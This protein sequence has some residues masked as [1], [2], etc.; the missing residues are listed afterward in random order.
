MFAFYSSESFSEI[1]TISFAKK[2][3]GVK[4]RSCEPLPDCGAQCFLV[5]CMKRLICNSSTISC[6]SCLYFSFSSTVGSDSQHF[7][8]NHN[9]YCQ[10]HC[11]HSRLLSE[12]F[13]KSFSSLRS[14]LQLKI[15]SFF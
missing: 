7:S 12:L 6:K 10:I 2:T 5:L 9:L 8:S 11:G 4:S 1:E 13:K 15:R 3:Y 14:S